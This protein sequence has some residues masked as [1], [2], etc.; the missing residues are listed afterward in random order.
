MLNTNTIMPLPTVDEVRRMSAE[1]KA[2]FIEAR[3]R[4]VNR[5]GM[6]KI[7]EFLR[8]TDFY[9]APATNSNNSNYMGGLAEHSILVYALCI[10]LRD[11]LIEIKPETISEIPEESVI[12]SALLHDVCKIC[13]YKPVEKWKKDSSTGVEQWTSYQGY[14]IN[15]SFPIGHGEKSVIMLLNLGLTLTPTEMLAIRY[16]M[17][18]WNTSD[19]KWS[20]AKATEI[21]PLITLLQMADQMSAL[22]LE[23]KTQQ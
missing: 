15:D 5:N 1:Q 8:G 12:V 19:T 23:T 10:K 22:M 14:E 4:S 11:L 2:A 13:L 16:H 18:G 9:T 20:Y 6:E 7:I 21:C 3:L 17:G